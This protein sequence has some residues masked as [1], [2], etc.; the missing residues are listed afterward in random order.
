[1]H[2]SDYPDMRA[3][4]LKGYLLVPLFYSILIGRGD[5][6][7]RLFRRE[8]AQSNPAFFHPHFDLSQQMLRMIYTI[9]HN[10][11]AS[12]SVSLLSEK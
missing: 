8:V 11:S 5:D 2:K 6:G 9:L 10:V 1:M 12:Q 4:V 7:G 3:D